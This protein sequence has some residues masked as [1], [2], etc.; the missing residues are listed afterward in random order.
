MSDYE[1][2][3]DAGRYPRFT[4]PKCGQH[5]VLAVVFG[6]PGPELFDASDRGEVML[7]GCCIEPGFTGREVACTECGWQGV[8]R[9]D[10]SGVSARR[11]RR[12]DD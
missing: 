11:R 4:C 6:M 5:T 2:A 12:T 1:K 3:I 9:R 7:G 10:G 8:A